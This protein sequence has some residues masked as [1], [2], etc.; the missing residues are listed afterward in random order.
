MSSV[1]ISFGRGNPLLALLRSYI[2]MK[3][4]AFENVSSP[5]GLINSQ[6]CAQISLESFVC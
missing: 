6:T 3:N 2:V 1:G 4:W 5:L